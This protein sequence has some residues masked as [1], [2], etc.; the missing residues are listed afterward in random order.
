M[1]I[2]SSELL[3][4]QPSVISDAGSNGGH[5][6]ASAISSGVSGNIFPN[7]TQQQRISGIT[8]YR[9]VF[10]KVAD[11]TN[12]AL[13]NPYFFISSQTPADDFVT[14]F[15][16][17][18]AQI[19]SDVSADGES[20]S[21]THYGCAQLNA[22]VSASAG[23]IDVYVEDTGV[24]IFR[25]GDTIRISDKASIEGVGNEEYHLLSNVSLIGN[26][27]TLTLDG[28][29]TNNAY[30]A[31]STK[32]AS[33]LNLSDIECSLNSWVETTTA[34]TYDEVTYPLTLN[35][36]GGVSDNWTLTFSDATNFSVSGTRT[37][38]VGS[39]AIGSNFSPNNADFSQPYFTLDTAG[40]GGTWAAT[41]TI[42]FSTVHAAK[43]IWFKRVV[44]S[45]IS[46]FSNNAFK[47]ALYGES[48]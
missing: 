48:A 34:G 16:G 19:Q 9:K 38:S 17:T 43:A 42:A 33:V 35:N 12:Y 22:D 26:V 25:I 41:D 27:A 47:F 37:G 15:E 18:D 23:S 7:V 44:P 31:A 1:S 39:G 8:N 46:S 32:V 36:I 13:V 29:T 10:F 3:M 5:M 6:S 2:L 24:T 28:T 20:D 4:Y 14:F 21:E 11:N 45:G 30:V 40:W